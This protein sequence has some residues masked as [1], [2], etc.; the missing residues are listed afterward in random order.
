[1]GMEGPGCLEDSLND[2]GLVCCSESCRF[3][4]GGGG[5]PYDE[6]VSEA[7]LGA[8]E[9]ALI[10]FVGLIWDLALSSLRR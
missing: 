7:S 6:E 5:G 4:P 1:M 10:R 2:D 3:R 8:G 9:P